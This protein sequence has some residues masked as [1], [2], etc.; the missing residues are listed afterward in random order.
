MLHRSSISSR[1]GFPR[2]GLEF[3]CLVI[4]GLFLV[5]GSLTPFQVD[6]ES[7]RS[8]LA[9][10]GLSFWSKCNFGDACVN[11]LIYVPFGASLFALM[12]HRFKRKAAFVLTATCSAAM[13]LGLELCQ[14]ILKGRYASWWDVLFNSVGALIGAILMSLLARSIVRGLLRFRRSFQDAP[15]HATEAVV[16]F[17]LLTISVVPF[18]FVTTTKGLYASMHESRIPMA[19]ATVVGRPML[20]LEGSSRSW[21]DIAA[22]DMGWA[23]AFAVLGYVLVVRNRRE[24]ARLC[25]AAISSL[26]AGFLLAIV[27]EVL[28][29]FA[30]GHV[31]ALPDIAMH[32]AGVFVGVMLGVVRD[33]RRGGDT[34]NAF[35]NAFLAFVVLGQVLAILL[36]AWLRLLGGVAGRGFESSDWVPFA[37]LLA[38]PFASAAAEVMDAWC[39]YALMIIPA[40]IWWN[41]LMPQWAMSLSIGLAM[42]V[43]AVVGV[44][45]PVDGATGFS[46]QVLATFVAAYGTI[47]FV[48]FFS[49][50][51]L[52]AVPVT[53]DSMLCA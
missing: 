51:A 30:S 17:A 35:N 27:L 14:L 22:G 46:T 2:S 44:S 11:L 16:V 41:R 38:M 9:G 53:F 39:V 4:T 48:Q 13:S 12:R 26:G 23:V 37:D 10:N 29:L 45:G 24:G 8:L 47:R 34:E 18:D 50:D 32:G 20:L 33:W 6:F 49:D 43:A 3:P 7:L 42:T 25:D 40:Y 28:Q 15:L 5:L 52:G 36:P 31:F 19:A 21:E 1:T